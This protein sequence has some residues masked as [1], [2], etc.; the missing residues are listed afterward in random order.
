MICRATLRERG[1]LGRG[2]GGCRMDCDVRCRGT[3]CGK[4]PVLGLDCLGVLGRER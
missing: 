1:G 2:D 4:C 3:F